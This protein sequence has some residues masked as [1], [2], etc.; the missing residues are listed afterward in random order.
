M[1]GVIKGCGS[2]TVRA[3]KPGGTEKGPCYEKQVL[4]VVCTFE[5]VC[6]RR[7]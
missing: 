6:I 1:T 3:S 2:V 5:H 4:K 7:L